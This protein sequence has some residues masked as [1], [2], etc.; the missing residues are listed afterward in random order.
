MKIKIGEVDVELR[1]TFNSFK[2]MKELDISDMNNLDKKPFK[3][4]NVLS[5]L[6]YGA[7]NHNPNVSV[8]REESDTL[9]Q[10]YL[11]SDDCNIGEF[12]NK[13]V[14]MLLENDFFKQLQA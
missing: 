4:F 10:D 14:E 1:Y 11:S 7:V 2:Y 12:S 8:S 9:L 3:I 5:E 6:F 13:M